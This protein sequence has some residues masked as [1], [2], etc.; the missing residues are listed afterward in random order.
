MANKP[1]SQTSACALEGSP[2]ERRAA[3]LI[4]S[5]TPVVY[6]KAYPVGA[7]CRH[8]DPS[9]VPQ[10]LPCWSK[11]SSFPRPMS[12]RIRRGGLSSTG[13][14]VCTPNRA[15]GRATSLPIL[16]RGVTAARGGT[17]QYLTSERYAAQPAPQIFLIFH[18]WP[19]SRR[20]PK[21]SRRTFLLEAGR[22]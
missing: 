22:L 3:V 9:C 17:K 18:A 10:G 20:R 12:V 16:F 6:A 8:P 7:R 5:C 2:S 4:R 15:P 21:T 1:K 14:H 13:M 11:M 19:L